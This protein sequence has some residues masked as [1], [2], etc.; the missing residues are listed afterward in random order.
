MIAYELYCV[1]SCSWCGV[2]L[3]ARDRLILFAEFF[4]SFWFGSRDV[5]LGHYVYIRL[6]IGLLSGILTWWNGE[7]DVAASV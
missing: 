3:Q 4:G 1:E 7:I 6:L 2:C 5:C